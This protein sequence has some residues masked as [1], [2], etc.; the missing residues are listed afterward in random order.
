MGTAFG[1]IAAIAVFLIA[2]ATL[3][4]AAEIRT[5]S[6]IGVQAALE[7]LATKFEK[8]T[9]TKLVIT[10]GTG[11]GLAKRVQE[12]ESADLL[13]LTRQGVDTLAKDSKIDAGTDA[14]FASAG[15]GVA[16]KKGAPKPDISTPE[17]F[18]KTMLAAKSIA[19]SSPSSGG[20]SGA[21]FL[22]LSEKLGIAD[23]VKA[24]LKY[25]PDGSN[26]ADLAANGEAELAIAQEPEVK[27]VAGADLVG[28]FPAEVNNVT[29][30]TAAV[31]LNSKQ[32]D[33]AK[34]LIKYLQSPDA[35]AVFKARGLTPVDAPKG[36]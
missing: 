20:A 14:N 24:K 10:W 21:Y 28:P 6:S 33:A 25:P 16:V 30:F 19:T 29:M 34:A 7:E 5:F 9:G 3:A 18:K 15:M 36:S 31:G 17:A 35:A 8:A 22:K 13:V 32:A 27:A 26:A 1:R 12:G 11:A 23:E 4:C 2:Q